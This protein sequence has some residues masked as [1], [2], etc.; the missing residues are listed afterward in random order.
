MEYVEHNG[1]YKLLYSNQVANDELSFPFSI[2]YGSNGLYNCYSINNINVFR[3]IEN[4]TSER[5]PERGVSKTYS[6]NA[7]TRTY[8]NYFTPDYSVKFDRTTSSINI[9]SINNVKAPE[10]S[11][12]ANEE[13][14]TFKNNINTINNKQFINWSCPLLLNVSGEDERD[15][16]GMIDNIDTTAVVNYSDQY[17]VEEP[18]ARVLYPIGA[19]GKLFLFG[20]DTSQPGTS[21]ITDCNS[22][23]APSITVANVI[24]DTIPYGGYNKTAIDN[25]SYL[26]FGDYATRDSDSIKVFS[27]DTKNRIFTYNALHTWYDPTFKNCVKMATVYAI[28]VETDIDIQAQYGLL[29]GVDNFSNYNAQDVACAFDNYTQN[30]DAY[31]YNPAYNATPDIVTWTTPEVLETKQDGFDTRV[32]YSNV[33]TNNEDIDS[34]T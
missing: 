17:G 12:F 29:Y 26:S 7:K 13:V 31:M 4:Y 11:D 32:H 16:K 23:Y 24:K 9:N 28:P 19:G 22:D 5:S 2:P 14:L 18:R 3:L 15:I 21:L 10:Y 1:Q 30:K 20:V 34:W 33:K 25:S 27:G 6:D 8:F